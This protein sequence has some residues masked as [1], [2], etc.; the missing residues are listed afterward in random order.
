M[1]HC[2]TFVPRI[3][4]CFFGLIAIMFSSDWWKLGCSFDWLSK[5]WT[6]WSCLCMADVLLMSDTWFN[7]SGPCSLSNRIAIYELSLR[8]SSG[9]GSVILIAS[10]WL[11]ALSSFHT[12]FSKSCLRAKCTNRLDLIILTTSFSF[13]SSLRAFSMINYFFFL[14]QQAILHDR[15]LKMQNSFI[16]S[17]KETVKD[18]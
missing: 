9:G 6:I 7:L 3:A 13:S 17:V 10:Q 12:D 2:S 15:S 5:L 8:G 18:T 14:L 16:W 11:Y 4:F 1:P